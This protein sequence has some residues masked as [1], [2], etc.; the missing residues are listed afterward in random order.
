MSLGIML[1]GRPATT[2]GGRWQMA[3]GSYGGGGSGGSELMSALNWLAY[4]RR[5]S[6]AFQAPTV[7]RVFTNGWF[8]RSIL[9]APRSIVAATACRIFAPSRS[10]S[11]VF[12]PRI[13]F[14]LPI[15][16]VCLPH[17]GRSIP[18][19]KTMR[20]RWGTQCA[21]HNLHGRQMLRRLEC[22]LGSTN[23]AQTA[24]HFRD[25]SDGHEN[26][27]QKAHKSPARRH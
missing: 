22:T 18:T 27:A 5:C 14:F 26:P 1:A 11:G 21:V 12:S 4:L 7:P 16:R 2:V 24:A 20:V 17:L 8:L 3:A 19:K 15:H 13:T 10:A 6:I 23:D 25:V 9:P